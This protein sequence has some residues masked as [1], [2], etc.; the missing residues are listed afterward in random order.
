[1]VRVNID[2]IQTLKIK[3]SYVEILEILGGVQERIS[4]RQ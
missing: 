1:V 2:W 4:R 3:E